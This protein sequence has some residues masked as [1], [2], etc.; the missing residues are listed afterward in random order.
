MEF[1]FSTEEVEKILFESK[2]ILKLERE[3]R[4][5]PH[6]DDKVITAWNGTKWLQQNNGGRN[7]FFDQ[8]LMLACPFYPRSC[9]TNA[10]S[11]R[12]SV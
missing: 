12:R 10:V 1:G 7:L 5:R 3:K 6:L 4:P 2:L 11:V 8:V 9:R